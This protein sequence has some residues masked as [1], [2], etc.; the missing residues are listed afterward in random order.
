MATTPSYIYDL[1][2]PEL[3]NL[4][5]FMS[6]LAPRP[7]NAADRIEE[8]SVGWQE[9]AEDW[10][11][12]R[13]LKGETRGMRLVGERWLP[14]FSQE[15][16][17]EY[18]HRLNNSF[19]ID[20]LGDT[21]DEMV[22]K[23]F[24]KGISFSGTVPQWVEEMNKNVD[25][26]GT[27]IHEFAENVFESALWWGK[28][29]VAVDA[30]GMISEDEIPATPQVR[31][32]RG[33]RPRFRCVPGPNALSWRRSEDGERAVA[34]VRFYE[35]VVDGT[36]IIE[37]LHVW[38]DARLVEHQRDY[39]TDTFVESSS[40][41]NFVGALPIVTFYTK[42][43]A[44]FMAKPPFM[45][46]AWINVDHW[47]SYSDQRSI[48]HTARVPLLFK[49]GFSDK[50]LK[51]GATVVGAKRSVGTS[52][53][54]ADMHYVEVDGASMEQ[55]DK[56][57]KGLQD[58]AREK[59]AKPLYAKGPVTATGEYRADEKASCDIQ[60]WSQGLERV[61][62]DAYVFAQKTVPGLEPLPD[63][64]GVDVFS[65]FDLRDSS[66]TDLSG[67]AA[68]RVRGDISRVAYLTECKRRGRL[69]ED[70][71]IEADKVLLDQ[72]AA[73]AMDAMGDD[74]ELDRGE[75]KLGAKK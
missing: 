10:L 17:L 31:A 24:S 21:I 19:L 55:G 6:S 5:R 61:L 4:D 23:P 60:A 75:A 68:D 56:H 44:E 66:S 45:D 54:Q 65:D 49:R 40:R 69:P 74:E 37:L 36:Q 30:R 1:L 59:G 47:Q 9:M 32:F 48:L 52:N 8:P 11:V 46:I 2:H 34:E 7:V 39:T 18:Q 3:V 58:A 71:D 57:L 15:S 12:V 67:L 16:K 64:F 43:T 29:H 42:R 50:E 73:D 26:R 27:T 33:A 22:S 62:R 38:D 20:M 14:R 72:E 13:D 63:D 51:A 28:A 53:T 41:K 35:R 25:G 70:F